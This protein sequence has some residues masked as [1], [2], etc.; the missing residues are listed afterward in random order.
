MC[1]PSP[2]PLFSPLHC[3]QTTYSNLRALQP[4]RRVS[5]GNGNG[6]AVCLPLR[7]VVTS[8]V[9]DHTLSVFSI[10]H[11]GTF[12]LA[13][14]LGGLGQGPLQFNFGGA[15]INSGYLCFTCPLN[16]LYPTVLVTEDANDRVQ[17]VDTVTRS[18]VGYLY[19]PGAI[20]GPRAVAASHKYIAV[21]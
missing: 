18:H 12:P 14:T 3:T 6:L 10:T 1:S 15:V 2:S 7:A 4:V 13:H 11:D 20:C 21:R 16:G 8:T 9:T 5:C 19:P 17:E